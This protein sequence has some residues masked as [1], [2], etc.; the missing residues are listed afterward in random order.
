MNT[1]TP[2]PRDAICSE[3]AP[4]DVRAIAAGIYHK[5]CRTDFDAP[6]FCVVNVGR[7]IDSVAFRRLM[8][9]VKGEMARIHESNTSHTLVYQSAGRFDQQETTRPHL[10]GGPE[11]CLLMLGYEPSGVDSEVEIFDYARC[12]YDLGL[13]PK[14]LLAR[15]NPMFESGDELLRPYSTPA[16]CFT[17]AA[18]QIVCINN[19]WAPFSREKPAWQG[20]LHT[21]RVLSPDESERR[22]INSTMI[23]SVAK[24]TADAVTPSELEAFVTTPGVRRRGYDKLH[25]EDEG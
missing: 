14:E 11:E 10:D 9:E 1:V 15:H 3:P 23:A 20:V 17:P 16:V 13:A 12:A 6:G 18:Y 7:S 21:A 2:W 4:L 5:A 8:V 22:V 19:S 25:L 24:G